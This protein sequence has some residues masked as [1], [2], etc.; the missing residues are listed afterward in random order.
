M[1]YIKTVPNESVDLVMTDPPYE[2]LRRWEGVGTTAR[3]GMGKEGSGSDDE[4]NKFYP[5]IPNDDLPDLVQ[6]IYRVLKP[7]CH[8]YVMCDEITERLIYEYAVKELVFTPADEYGTEP[9]RR[10]IWDKMAPGMGYSYRR[11]YEFVVM[12]WKGEKKRKDGTRRGKRKLNDLGVPDILRFKRVPPIQQHVPTEKPVE[13]FELLIK[14][15]TQ[16]GE[17]VLD[18]FMGAG[19]T[20]VAAIHQ[21]RQWAGCELLQKHAD[22]ANMRIAKEMKPA[23]PVT[24]ATPPIITTA[25]Q[26]PLWSEQ[27]A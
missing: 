22:R 10:L 2:S 23:A 8:A 4:E 21:S 25:G 16:P 14:Q 27:T 7:G 20:A 12:M 17:L 9:Y 19:T 3:M 6:H 5:T 26:R 11:Q 18:M 24:V 1:D 15:S 13:L